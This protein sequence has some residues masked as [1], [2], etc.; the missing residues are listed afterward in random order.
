MVNYVNL[1]DHLLINRAPCW[2]RSGDDRWVAPAEAARLG[3]VAGRGG[4][5]LR[6]LAAR[7]RVFRSDGAGP[8]RRS[9][10]TPLGLADGA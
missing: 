7:S 8:R 10:H 9:G 1:T 2:S 4:K 3:G 5:A 6:D